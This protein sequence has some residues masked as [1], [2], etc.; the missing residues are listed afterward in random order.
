MVAYDEVMYYNK[1]R[2]IYAEFLEEKGWIC[3]F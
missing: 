3:V 1:K 2:R